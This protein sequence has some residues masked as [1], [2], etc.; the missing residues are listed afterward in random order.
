MKPQP[1]QKIHDVVVIDIE[2]GDVLLDWFHYSDKPT[3]QLKK[4]RGYA[5]NAAAGNQA[6]A[7]SEQAPFTSAEGPLLN[8]GQGVIN[9]YDEFTPQ[10]PSATNPS[11]F[12]QSTQAQYAADLANLHSTYGG[13]ANSG[14]RAL[15]QRGFGSA[16]TGAA[17][18]LE[19]TMLSN[20][21]NQEANAYRNAQV[22]NTNQGFA[23]LAGKQGALGGQR[24]TL[25]LYNPVNTWNSV[26]NN[27]KTI[28]SMGSTAGDIG[29]GLSG[30]AG[31]FGGVAG[32]MKALNL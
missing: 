20:E 12:S 1:L 27:G 19:N 6:V 14:F 9:A 16:P 13:L 21:G 29:A 25:G 10:A 17:S 4:G 18:S 22:N 15:A 3:I 5:N 30:L 28:N 26:A 31:T 32:G 8:E 11:G 23:A 24:Q 2:T 7:N